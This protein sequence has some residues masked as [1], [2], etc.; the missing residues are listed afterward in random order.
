LVFK[1]KKY[2]LEKEYYA[3]VGGLFNIGETAAE[4]A[5]RELLE[6]TGLEATE[7]VS[8]GRYRVQVNRGGGILY[9]FLA[10]NS[11]FS[12]KRS[13]SDD[14]EKQTNVKVRTYF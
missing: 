12:K 14:Y 13:K 2:G 10:K 6:E 7:L 3:M 11:F 4:C 8:L 5:R 9:S 1:Q